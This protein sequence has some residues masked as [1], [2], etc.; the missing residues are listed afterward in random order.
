MAAVLDALL[1]RWES[2]ANLLGGQPE[3]LRQYLVDSNTILANELKR[4]SQ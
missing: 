2:E 1:T 4:L 3:A